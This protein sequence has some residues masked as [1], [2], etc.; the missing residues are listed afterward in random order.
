VIANDTYNSSQSVT[1]Y[2][3]V[4]SVNPQINLTSPAN[5][6][7]HNSDFNFTFS[8]GEDNIDTIYWSND[9]YVTNYSF[10]YV[11]DS[12]QVIVFD[13]TEDF[14]EDSAFFNTDGEYTDEDYDTIGNR[15][16]ISQGT[17]NSTY[18]ITYTVNT[19]QAYEGVIWQVKDN[20]GTRN[21]TL[22]ASSFSGVNLTVRI[23]YCSND[24][25]STCFESSNDSARYEV[26]TGSGWEYLGVV[27]GARDFY[28]ESLFYVNNTSV[29]TK[30]YID[31][32][33]VSVWGEG[34]QTVAVWANDSAG[35]IGTQNFSFFID[36]SAPTIN[37]THPLNTSYASSNLDFNYTATDS[38]SGI[39]SCFYSLN[40]DS[41]VTISNCVNTTI[42]PEE[43]LNNITLYVNDT[44]GNLAS[45]IEYFT[46]NIVKA[47]QAVL[48]TNAFIW[49]DTLIVAGSP[50]Y[51]VQPVNQTG[52]QGT[53][54]ITNN[55]SVVL[56]IQF[57]LSSD[58]NTGQVY[59]IN[60]TNQTG[61]NQLY[62]NNWTT[63]CEDLPVSGV[64][65]VWFWSNLTAVGSRQT[66]TNIS[67]DYRAVVN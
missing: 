7:Y 21:F 18:N 39:A 58:P 66:L 62:S 15:V 3:T 38:G 9:S 31:T 27:A 32:V 54:N 13:D 1:W 67:F 47:V 8:V 28:E 29:I 51:Y 46:A 59:F 57:Q 36:L 30:K 20:I 24:G 17:I 56:D 11:V 34:N 60:S 52:A 14:R 6:S 33:D 53:F 4:D 50:N 48:T 55:D 40:G 12:Y 44:L 5:Q 2:F 45:D 42:Q 65:S 23:D 22:P 19:A 16:F 41:N 10:T 49:G 43:G 26:F 63:V 37:I 25:N 64:C 35:N 61:E